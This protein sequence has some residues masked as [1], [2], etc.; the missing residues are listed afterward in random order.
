MGRL[1]GPEYA[2]LHARS[3]FSLLEGA[4]TPERLATRAAELGLNTLAL[5][6]LHDLGGAVRFATACAEYGVRPIFGAEV[7]LSGD[8]SIVLLI[9]DTLV[10]LILLLHLR[11]PYCYCY[12]IFRQV[13][14]LGSRKGLLRPT[15]RRRRRHRRPPPPRG[16]C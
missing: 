14:S 9:E 15:R 2:E 1:N 13:S 16:F 7:N 11:T 12:C 8:G 5:T 6:D 4:S 3:A 10:L